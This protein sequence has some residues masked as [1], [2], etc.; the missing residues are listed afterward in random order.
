M[1]AGAGPFQIP[2]FREHR[3]VVATMGTV[4]PLAALRSD[5]ERDADEWAIANA[6]AGIAS[7]HAAP[8]GALTQRIRAG[9]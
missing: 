4:E 5:R 1:P 8:S 3:E 6:D 7:A 2:L 9:A